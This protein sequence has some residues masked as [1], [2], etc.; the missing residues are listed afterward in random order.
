MQNIPS[1]NL[2][3]LHLYRVATASVFEEAGWSLWLSCSGY[4]GLC[5]TAAHRW[6][7]S[8]QHQLA[9]ASVSLLVVCEPSINRPGLSSSASRFIFHSRERLHQLVSLCQRMQRTGSPTSDKITETNHLSC[10]DRGATRIHDM[11]CFLTTRIATSVN[12]YLTGWQA[13]QY[14][15]HIRDGNPMTTLA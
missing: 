4:Q 1:D 7:I 13:S 11:H 14:N 8:R 12:V 6:S 9:R 15:S 5:H 10:C 3:C 2:S